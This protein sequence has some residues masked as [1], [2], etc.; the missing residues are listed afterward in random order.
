M[1]LDDGVNHLQNN[2]NFM[3]AVSR[4][5]G[6]EAMARLLL[7]RAQEE[8]ERRK[9]EKEE[10]ERRKQEEIKRFE[11]INYSFYSLFHF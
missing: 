7:K 1:S 10:E 8:L 4:A 3:P 6:G 9:R 5:C 2:T 11:V